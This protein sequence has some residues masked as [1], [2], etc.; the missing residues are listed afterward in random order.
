M[1]LD[2]SEQTFY[3]YLLE[4]EEDDVLDQV[5]VLLEAGK[6]PLRIAEV[7]KYAM[8]EIGKMF[9]KKEIFLTELIMSGEL[10]NQVME[11]LGFSAGGSGG[12]DSDRKGK[13]LFGT[14]KGDVHDI[15]KNIVISL[16]ASNKYA[17]IDLGV[18]VPP[19]EFVKN[20]ILKSSII[21]Q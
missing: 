9:E 3:D 10:L 11:K 6:E 21:Q 15:G 14:V 13:I 16:L 12:D 4:F 19:E 7:A 5:D 8:D 2:E 18:D 20:P 1:E 17:V